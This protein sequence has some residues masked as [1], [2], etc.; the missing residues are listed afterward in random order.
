MGPVF[1][2]LNPLRYSWQIMVL[3]S[4]LK[5]CSHVM[6]HGVHLGPTDQLLCQVIESHTFNSLWN[7]FL[8][9]VTI[10]S[11]HSKFTLSE[12]V[13]MNVTFLTFFLRAMIKHCWSVEVGQSVDFHFNN[14]LFQIKFTIS[15]HFDFWSHEQCIS[16]LVISLVTYCIRPQTV[17]NRTLAYR[18]L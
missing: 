12:V 16:W 9:T 2:E 6:A 1:D 3:V 8:K 10:P 15:W 5:D 14:K 17:A 18:A 4:V 11:C 13:E 7:P